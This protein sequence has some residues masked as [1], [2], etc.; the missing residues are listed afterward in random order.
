MNE[1]IRSRAETMPLQ[2]LLRAAAA[3]LRH[4][5][6]PEA[7][8][9]RV[10]ASQGRTPRAARRSRT[11]MWALAGSGA[12]AGGMVLALALMSAGPT[13]PQ[14]HDVMRAASG[15][16]PVAS[17]ARWQQL[18]K[19]SATPAWLVSTELPRDR[20]AALG[21]PYDPARAA[22]PVRAELLLHA[23]GEVLALRVIGE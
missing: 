16:V 11:W 18:M 3:E 21:L 8:H 1:P 9:E 20:L 19:D 12:L 23:S 4:L 22:E 15:F 14:R 7:L 2:E 5:Q 10:L 17:A 6:P 13:E